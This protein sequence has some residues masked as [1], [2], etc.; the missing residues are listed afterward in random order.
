MQPHQPSRFSGAHIHWPI[1]IQLHDS[2][3]LFHL[4]DHQQWP[5]FI[6]QNQHNLFNRFYINDSK[7]SRFY[8]TITQAISYPLK[9]ER[10]QALTVKQLTQAVQA[11]AQLQ[12]QC[13]ASKLQITSLEQAMTLVQQLTQID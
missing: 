10:T 7:G 6:A 9:L 8:I 3:E 13:C 1:L 12:Q 2:D 5:A 4:E 11:Y